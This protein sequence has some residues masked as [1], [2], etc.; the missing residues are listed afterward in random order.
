MKNAFQYGIYSYNGEDTA[1]SRKIHGMQYPDEEPL[2]AI[3]ESDLSLISDLVIG[4]GHGLEPGSAV[5]ISK[6]GILKVAGSAYWTDLEGIIKNN[7][8]IKLF[9]YLTA[10]KPTISLELSGL[11][12]KVLDLTKLG[13]P[14]V[15][16]YNIMILISRVSNK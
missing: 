3:E 1:L 5:D 9:C 12:N 8:D 14:P 13:I 16:A 2:W 4:G 15:E 11:T 7:T 10:T 6:E